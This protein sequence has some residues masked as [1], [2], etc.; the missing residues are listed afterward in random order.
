VNYRL[1]AFSIAASLFTSLSYGQ[2]AANELPKKSVIGYA[3]VSEAFE[4][5]KSKPGVSISVTKPDA[6]VII[7][8]PITYTQWSF[9]PMGHYAHPAVV[10][11]EV[12][13]KEGNVYIEMS[14]LCQA[15]KLACDKII[16]EFKQ[17]GERM[18]KSIQGNLNK[19]R[20]K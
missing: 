11:R 12:K 3:T 13:Q 15:E 16:E 9:T 2:E 6:W 20:Q 8:E 14:A 1:L 18:T 5:L 4:A 7:N 17:L 10:R 19:G